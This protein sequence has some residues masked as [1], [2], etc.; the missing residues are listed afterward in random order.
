MAI[1][2]GW[3]DWAERRE[4]LADKVYSQPNAGLGLALHSMEGSVRGGETRFLSTERGQDGRY[5]EYAA[6]S[7]MFANPR[8]GPLI[9]Y[10]P[11]TASTWTSGNR[12]ANTT[13]WAVESEGFATELLN[14][15]QVSTMLRLAAEFTTHT[16][17]P[18]TRNLATR[19]IWEHR[20]VWNWDPHNAGPTACPS[21]R[22]QP[23]YEAL[24]AEMTSED[25]EL[26]FNLARIVLAG[27]E[28]GQ[29]PAAELEATIRWRA[30]E[31]AAKEQSLRERLIAIERKLNGG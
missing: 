5:T 23:F 10:Y 25:R 27:S 14:D 20:E 28:E 6:A 2:D 21:G 12:T 30:M 26:L 24:E 16:G 19:T 4:G 29:K 3:F 18:A 9:Q 17:R 11:V 22:Y 13:L 31:Y 1:V 7:V 15:H 8:A